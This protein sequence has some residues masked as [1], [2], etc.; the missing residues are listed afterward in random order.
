MLQNFLLSNTPQTKLL[1]WIE[2]KKVQKGNIKKF[3]LLLLEVNTNGLTCRSISE[4]SGIEVQSLTAPLKELETEQKI[5]V[6]GIKISTVSNRKVQV[7][8]LVE[9]E[10]LSIS[11]EI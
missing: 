10:S 3:I 11:I 4:I 9:C 8:S 5:K 6:T 1:S 2:F 7:Y